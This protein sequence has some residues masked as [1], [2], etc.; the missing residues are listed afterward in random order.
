[1]TKIYFPSPRHVQLQAHRQARVV[2][3]VEVFEQLCIDLDSGEAPVDGDDGPVDHGSTVAEQEGNDCRYVVHFYDAEDSHRSR[4]AHGERDSAIHTCSK[5][6]T[7][8]GQEHVLARQPGIL[9][10][11]EAEYDMNQC[12]STGRL[13]ARSPVMRIGR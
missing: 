12:R 7:K 9:R 3:R 11:Q 2:W 6:H 10:Q 5:R 13:D 8:S 1:M 4:Q